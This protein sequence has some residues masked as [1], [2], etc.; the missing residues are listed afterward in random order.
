MSVS[1]IYSGPV[2]HK[3]VRPRPHAL[4]YRIFM[5]LLDLDELENLLGRLRLLRRGR[6]G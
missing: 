4:R 2:F 1:A 3:R 6:F 5:L